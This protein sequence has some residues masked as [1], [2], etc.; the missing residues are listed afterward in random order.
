MQVLTTAPLLIWQ[1]KAPVSSLLNGQLIRSMLLLV[2]QLRLLMEEEVE[3]MDSMHTD[4]L[5]H[6]VLNASLMAC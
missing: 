5:P 3:P 4:G 6:G 1:V 2:Q